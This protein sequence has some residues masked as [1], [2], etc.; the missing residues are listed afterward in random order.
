MPPKKKRQIPQLNPDGTFSLVDAPDESPSRLRR[1]PRRATRGVTSILGAVNSPLR[2][3]PKLKVS[4]KGL[5]LWAKQ[6]AEEKQEE[7]RKEEAKKRLL[8]RRLLL[9]KKGAGEGS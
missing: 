2:P 6:E 5:A 9:K 3:G 1:N 4:D 8:I 7:K